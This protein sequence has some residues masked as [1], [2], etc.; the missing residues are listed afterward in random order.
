MIRINLLG[1]PKPKRGK[2][3]VVA[4]TVSAGEGLN[5]LV[6]GLLV[7]AIAAA[8]NGLWFW[9]LKHDAVKIQEDI[10]AAEAR[11]AHLQQVKA[12]YEEREQQRLQYQRRLDVI[13]QLQRNQAGPTTLLTALGSTVNRTDEVWLNSMTDDGNAINMKGVALSI[14]AV[15]S[16]M[17]HLQ[18]TG[19][20]KSVEIKTSYQD[21]GVKD[22]QAFVFELTCE[23]QPQTP[24]GAPA[25][26]AKKS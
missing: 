7:F 1:G 25:A 13:H 11:I 26:P 17:R 21:E 8:G 20:F 2:R 18:S 5:L 24:A 3:A 10:Q 14:H 23:K 22:M 4:A 6:V 16:L 19:Q 9:K 15:A 12:L